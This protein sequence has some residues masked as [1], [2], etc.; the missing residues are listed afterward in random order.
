[1]DDIKRCCKCDFVKELSEFSFRKDTQKYRNQCRDCIKLIIKEYQ[2]INKDESKIRNK[3]YRNNTKNLRDYMIWIIVNVIEKRFNFIRKTIFKII[4]KNCI[5]K[6]KRKDGDNN[7]RLACNLRKRV[8]NALKAQNA[9]KTNKT[10]GLLGCSHS[11][12][13]L[14]I[15]SHL[16]AEMTLEYYGNVWCLDP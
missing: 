14:W 5:R 12:L 15:E 13:R 7:F 1:M 6:L 9:R 16:Y 2:T 4:K 8:L 11:F 3:E 10:F